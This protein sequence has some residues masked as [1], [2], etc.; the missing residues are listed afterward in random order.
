VM[1]IDKFGGL[2]GGCRSVALTLVIF[3]GIRVSSRPGGSDALDCS[4]WGFLCSLLLI[5]RKKVYA[6]QLV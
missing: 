2:R 5:G 3:E 1:R 4:S 6:F